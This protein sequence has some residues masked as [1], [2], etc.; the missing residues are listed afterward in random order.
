MAKPRRLPT[1]RERLF[2]NVGFVVF[3]LVGFVGLVATRAVS[4]LGIGGYALGG[5]LVFLFGIWGRI[6]GYLVARAKSPGLV[7]RKVPKDQRPLSRQRLPAVVEMV[8][9]FGMLFVFGLTL[10]YGVSQL[11]GGAALGDFLGAAVIAG[12]LTIAGFILFWRGW[13]GWRRIARSVSSRL[14]ETR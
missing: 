3:A 4:G 10:I 11:E 9:G 8:V 2:G 14:A 13:K 7:A 1:P 5:F 6:V 12:A